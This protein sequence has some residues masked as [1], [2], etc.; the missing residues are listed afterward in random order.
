MWHNFLGRGIPN[1]RMFQE[2]H[3]ISIDPNLFPEANVAVQLMESAGSH[4]SSFGKDPL[5]G[6]TDLLQQREE[7]FLSQFPQFD[8]FFHTIGGF[9]EVSRRLESEITI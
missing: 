4:F 6:H 1:Q 2:N 8:A 9:I 3:V 7:A 5:D